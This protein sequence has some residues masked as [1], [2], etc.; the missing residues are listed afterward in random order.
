[1][2]A[3]DGMTRRAA[4]RGG[5]AG[6]AWLAAPAVAAGSSGD[7]RALAYRGMIDRG[8]PAFLGIRYARAARFDRPVREPV[9]TAPTPATQFGPLCPQRGPM[10]PAMSEDCLFLNIWT[11][12]AHPSA[13]RP[14]MVYFH[15][16]AYNW[17]SVTDPLT[18]GAK[19]AEQGDVVVVTVNHRLNLFGYG[20]LA[21][22]GERFRHSGNAGQLDLICALEWIREHIGSFGGDAD[23]VMVF[24][25]SGGGAKI[26]TLMAMPAADGLFH[27]AATMSG[28]QV[29]A[30]G[31]GN[32]WRRTRALLDHLGL[33][34]DGAALLAL[35]Y[36]RLLEGL[37]A[38]DPVLGGS[39]YFGPTLDMLHLHRHPFW[40]DA[41]PQSRHIPMILGNTRDE[42]RAFIRSDGP[43]VQGLDWQNIAERLAPQIR[44][45][46]PADWVVEQYRAQFP[47]WSAEQLYQLDRP[48]PIDP[49]R[50]AAHTDDLPYVFGTLAAPGS[51]SGTGPRARAVSDAMITAFAG[52]AHTGRPGLPSW[53]PY[54]LADRETL[55][56][57]DDRIATENDPRGWERELWARA[58]YIQPGS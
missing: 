11:P 46:L 34:E 57:G 49:T 25:Q 35:P 3:A 58:P 9:P 31:P 48:S 33:A 41:A 6:G 24:G 53:A 7:P 12:D 10:S 20:W 27:T 37:E 36:E 5:L 50:G 38:S 22:L 1:M 23:R 47:Q 44:I 15:G 14:V 19:L 39:L 52:M 16:G 2:S 18:H 42:T 51:Y 13:R 26:A 54:T 43:V 17:G 30:Q 45:D 40:P 55:V 4:L 32:G 21:R 28:Q 29:T 8:V 56:I